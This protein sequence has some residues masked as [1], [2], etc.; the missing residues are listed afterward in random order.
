[1]ITVGNLLD[2]KGRDVYSVGPDATVFEAVE[3]MAD[4]GVGALL[5]M[6]GKKLEGIVS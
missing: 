5:V 2:V 3:E 4:R 6:K 1:M